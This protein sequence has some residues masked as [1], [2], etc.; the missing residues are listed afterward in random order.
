[1]LSKIKTIFQ[2]PSLILIFAIA[3]FIV[4]THYNQSKWQGRSVI[5]HDVIS[6]YAYLPAVFIEKDI[7]LSFM[8]D[9]NEAKYFAAFKY[10]PVKTKDGKR[11]IKM[12]MGLSYLY[13]PFFFIAHTLAKNLG[14]EADGFSEPYHYAVQFS[15]LLYLIIALLWLRKLLLKHYNE[16]IVTLSIM[17]VYFGTNLLCYSTLQS[18][19]S[20]QY[21]FFLFT[22][23]IY[24][25]IS[26]LETRKLKYAFLIGLFIGLLVIVRPTNIILSLFLLLYNV[27]TITSLKER[28]T[29]F[30]KKT[31]QITL[32]III[33]FLIF[34]PQMIY[35]KIATGSY[36][37]FSYVGEGFFFNDPHVFQILFSFRNGWLI[38][39]PLMLLA[40]F[41]IYILY[42]NKSP[43][44]LPTIVILPIILY[45]LSSWWCWWYGG[46]F[47]FRS[48]IDLYPI[49]CF[50]IA[51]TLHFVLQRS[52]AIKIAGFSI[53]TVFILMNLFQTIQ[54]HYNIIQYDSMT[55]AAYRDR[56]FK[57]NRAECDKAL[58]KRPDY[59]L[60]KKGID[61][62]VPFEGE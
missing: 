43:Y 52:K 34:L 45:L 42:N 9:T 37:Y 17:I 44:F 39:S 6:Y 19:L 54:Y 47:G 12:S 60:A 15:G 2:K 5:Q 30:I 29:L 50:G 53:I 25:S 16:L 32:I 7:K 55:F 62:T 26:W 22:G 3:V 8:N 35:W 20:H 11:I 33:A 51:A 61:A 57:I 41:G 21:N 46:S 14:F 10:W 4:C 18:A 59:N 49:L 48:M 27:N 36:L 1:M 40:L 24:F 38:Y 58:L 28:V 56:F 13:A 23:L 31:P